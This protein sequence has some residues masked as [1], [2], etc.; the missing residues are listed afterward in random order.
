MPLLLG[1]T[2]DTLLQ[3]DIRW[4]PL[5]YKQAESVCTRRKVEWIAHYY[6]LLGLG[7]VL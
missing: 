7:P 6:P 4:E 1:R 3:S 5:E 2:E